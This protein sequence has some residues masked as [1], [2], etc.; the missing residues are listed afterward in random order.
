MGKSERERERERKREFVLKYGVDL[1]NECCLSPWGQV[2]L[3]RQCNW[4]DTRDNGFHQ[5][6]LPSCLVWEVSLAQSPRWHFLSEW[7]LAIKPARWSQSAF[8][9]GRP[10]MLT[11]GNMIHQK[12]KLQRMMMF[13]FFVKYCF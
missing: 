12:K 8:S 6:L 5:T 13:S 11:I 10:T 2:L 9:E 4:D 3:P 7:L 1:V